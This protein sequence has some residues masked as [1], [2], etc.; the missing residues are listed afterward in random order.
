[1]PR[2]NG[3]KQRSTKGS[4]GKVGK[5]GAG[6]YKSTAEKCSEVQGAE[7]KFGCRWRK[8]PATRGGVRA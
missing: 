1:M 4:G 8:R 2:V 3:K 7:R 5:R 6:E